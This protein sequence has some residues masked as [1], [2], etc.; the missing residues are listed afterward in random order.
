MKK[1]V[2]KKNGENSKTKATTN[3]KDRF[4]LSTIKQFFSELKVL[5]CFCSNVSLK[6]KKYTHITAKNCFIQRG[7]VF[8]SLFVLFMPSYMNIFGL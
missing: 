8:N 5:A 2:E 7:D 1:K 4:S 3:V 6:I